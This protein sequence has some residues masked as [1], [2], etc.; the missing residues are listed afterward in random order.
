MI[1]IIGLL[2]WTGAALEIDE[3]RELGEH[4]EIDPVWMRRGYFPSP[5]GDTDH[6]T[7]GA[8]E[9]AGLVQ[10]G[11]RPVRP[12]REQRRPARDLLRKSSSVS[13]SRLAMIVRNSTSE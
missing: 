2:G 3:F 8:A 6:T 10:V 11:D 5:V 1:S 9:Q 12:V 7:L 13:A 4:L